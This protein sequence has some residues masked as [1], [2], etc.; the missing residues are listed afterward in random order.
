MTPEEIFRFFGI[1]VVAS[2][3]VLLAVFGMTSLLGHPLS[4]RSQARFTEASVVF[5]LISALVVLA[6]M[7]AL[8]TRHVP[9]E[10]GNWVAIDQQH[11][12]FHLKFVFDRLSVPFAILTF[13]LCGT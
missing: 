6:L 2:P 12:H 8:D 7:L 5:G 4:E 3:A 13:V 1:C 9:L 10:L 11:F